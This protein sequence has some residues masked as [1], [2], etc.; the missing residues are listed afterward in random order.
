MGKTTAFFNNNESEETILEATEDIRKAVNTSSGLE[1][2]LTEENKSLDMDPELRDIANNAA[3][4]NIRYT[5]SARDS[6]ATDQE[7]A[8]EVTTFLNQVYNSNLHKGNEFR[9]EVA[10]QNQ[11]GNYVLA[12]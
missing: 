6:S 7:T 5:L 8:K 2:S 9:G 10:Y 3:E 1:L 11:A 12:A 4:N